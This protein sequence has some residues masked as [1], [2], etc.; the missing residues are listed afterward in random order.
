MN[1]DWAQDEG[2]NGTEGRCRVEKSVRLWE[3]QSPK[4]MGAGLSGLDG[5]EVE[6]FRNGQKGDY[7]I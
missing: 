3:K 2:G 1:A 6:V 7:L 4:A 5:P